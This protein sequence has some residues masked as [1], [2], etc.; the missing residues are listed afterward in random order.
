MNIKRVN[1]E[2][3]APYFTGV[4][5]MKIYC[6]PWCTGQPKPENTVR[7]ESRVEA[8]RAGYR[9]CKNCCSGLPKGS[10]EDNKQELILITPK[11]FSFSENMKYMS[12]S[13]DECLFH[14]RDQKI[15]KAIPVGQETPVVE[16]SSNSENVMTIRFIGETTPSRRWV[17]AEV[18]RYVREWFDL[19][20]DLLPFYEMARTDALLQRAV[21]S[22][23]G[24]RTIGIPDLFEAICWG[25][26]GQQINLTFAYTLKR[27][28]VETFG[29]G[30]EC[31][32]ELYWVFPTPDEI[33]AL[34]VEDLGLLRM[35]VKKCEYLIGVARLIAAG[36]LTKELLL[37]AGD[38]KK[39]EKMLVKVRG[40]GP[41]TAN[42]VL[43]RC[44]RF[45]SAFPIDDVGLHNSIKHLQG[46]E[47]KPTK[48]EIL[49]LSST[50]TNWESYATFYL[51]RF[52]Y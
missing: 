7:F 47:N 6:F 51:W 37:N 38:D 40:I 9:S 43:M 46:T 21:D 11:E 26:I 16:I 4:K 23:Y 36:E 27:R 17:R 28:L 2:W 24:L 39:A 19:D 29:R 32:G 22:F 34:T 18:A 1:A 13:P 50:W 33:A 52:L 5:T 14:T 42:Y 3:D 48:N 35:T 15:Y 44:L 30:L 12:N 10:W 20:T 49:Q 45:P 8:E 25:I 41:W 31:E